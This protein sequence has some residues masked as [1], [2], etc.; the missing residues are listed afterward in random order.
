MEKLVK[1]IYLVN[2]Y[3]FAYKNRDN[4]VINKGGT[5]FTGF[6]KFNDDNAYI[7]NKRNVTDN[8][9]ILNVD[10]HGLHEYF[11]VIPEGFAFDKDK[12]C[13]FN[14]DVRIPL[15]LSFDTE[16]YNVDD[17]MLISSV[18]ENFKRC[19]T[20][21]R[22][23]MSANEILKTYQEINEN[24][25]N[26]FDFRKK[27]LEFYK[28]N[29]KD[30]VKVYKANKSIDG[31][32]SYIFKNI[33][34]DD[35]SVYISSH[36]GNREEQEDNSVFATKN[37]VKF[38]GVFDGMGGTTA[39]KKASLIVKDE[40]K[41]WFL[42][43]NNKTFDDQ[44]KLKE[45]MIEAFKCIHEKVCKE[46]KTNDGCG[47][48]TLTTAI[49]NDKLNNTLITNI[50]DSR[51]YGYSDKLDL[52]T[53]DHRL[54]FWRQNKSIKSLDD[55]RYVVDPAIFDYIGCSSDHEII[56]EFST[57]SNKYKKLLLFTDGVTDIVASSTI[58][59]LCKLC[60]N[61]EKLIKEIMLRAIYG[62]EEERRFNPGK[63]N[64]TAIVYTRKR[65]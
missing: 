16:N 21:V 45:S 37:D 26:V 42:T 3:D 57:I 65:K 50:G 36:K 29:V 46:T 62:T 24:S 39:G 40:I 11:L 15:V 43:E 59:K 1:E 17:Y 44:K 30:Q 61:D 53:N 2:N 25:K 18:V 64:A 22:P 7:C 14:K 52:L 27:I 12:M 51:L 38:L 13:I 6:I 55:Y 19:L 20:I 8:D 31:D 32:E 48:S 60:D 28:E 23:K 41:D 4:A 49:I 56:P 33:D 35:S 5:R 9:L 34:M 10:R 58:A 54:S 63:Y 47:G